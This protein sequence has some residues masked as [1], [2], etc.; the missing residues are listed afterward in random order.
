MSPRRAPYH[1]GLRETRQCLVV[2]QHPGRRQGDPR[3]RRSGPIEIEEASGV[4]PRRTTRAGGRKSIEI[5]RRPAR[6]GQDPA[7][8]LFLF[9]ESNWPDSLVLGVYFLLRVSGGSPE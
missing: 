4:S 1:S 8:T 7:G 6:R 3:D 5:S 2:R 9:M